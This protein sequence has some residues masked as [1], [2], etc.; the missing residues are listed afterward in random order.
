MD[1]QL[2]NSEISKTKDIYEPSRALMR[3]NA[4]I[5][6]SITDI[7]GLDLV[8]KAKELVIISRNHGV[9]RVDLRSLETKVYISRP[10]HDP[11]IIDDYI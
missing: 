7:G 4:Q 3:L 9:P 1:L 5:P 8:L 6:A 2:L 11:S 10:Y